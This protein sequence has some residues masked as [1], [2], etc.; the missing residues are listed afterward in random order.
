[1]IYSR[2]ALHLCDLDEVVICKSSNYYHLNEAEVKQNPCTVDSVNCM[3]G[4]NVEINVKWHDIMCAR[5]Y[6]CKIVLWVK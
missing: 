4:V 3:F 5:S 6:E 2:A 1:M